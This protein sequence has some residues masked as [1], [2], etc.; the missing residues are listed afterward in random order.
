MVAELVSRSSLPTSLSSKV[1]GKISAAAKTLQRHHG[2]VVPPAVSAL[3]AKAM[4]GNGKDPDVLRGPKGPPWFC[5]CGGDLPTG[6]WASRTRCKICKRDAPAHIAKRARENA[7]R[8]EKQPKPTAGVPHVRGKKSFK[9]AFTDAPPWKAAEAERLTKKVKELE[10]KNSKLEATLAANNGAGQPG[11]GASAEAAAATDATAAAEFH[12]KKA[13]YT[14]NLK[15]MEE[16]FGTDNAAT[17]EVRNQLAALELTRPPISHKAAERKAQVLEKRLEKLK[18]EKQDNALQLEKLQKRQEEVANLEAG[19][20]RELADLAA[21][22]CINDEASDEALLAAL[23]LPTVAADEVEQEGSEG[24]ADRAEKLQAIRELAR[25]LRPSKPQTET[26]D[27]DKSPAADA[28]AGG[29]AATTASRTE[30][31]LAKAEVSPEEFD[32]LLDEY[33]QARAAMDSVGALGDDTGDESEQ[34]AAAK[35]RFNA[36]RGKIHASRRFEPYR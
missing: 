8:A 22:R 24:K 9:Q 28:T 34:K 29:N 17:V 11:D 32:K 21:C 20:Q 15:F 33:N 5:S 18:A 26:M 23:G 13:R 27:V 16:N 12:K 14:A 2:S 10:L 31:G 6:N 19:L 30:A 1:L 4:P 35:E 7:A 3:L 36:V 25:Q